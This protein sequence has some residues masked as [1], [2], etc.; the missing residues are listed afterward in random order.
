M[1]LPALDRHPTRR[2]LRQFGWGTA[3]FLAVV[4]WPAGASASALWLRLAAAVIFAVATVLPGALRWPYLTL[5]FTLS[6]LVRLFG[7]VVRIYLPKAGA[8]RLPGREPERAQ[9]DHDRQ[10]TAGTH[11]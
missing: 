11:G 6:I 2:Q 1:H 7:R 5:F 9:D 4:S 10:P 3:L 8:R